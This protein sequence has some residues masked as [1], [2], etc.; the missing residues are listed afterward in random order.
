MS[1]AIIK[2]GGKQFV[3]EEGQHDS[4]PFDRQLKPA[5]N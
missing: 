5:V 2:A 1:Y 3:V 4:R